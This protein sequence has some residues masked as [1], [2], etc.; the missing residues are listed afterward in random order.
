MVDTSQSMRDYVENFRANLPAGITY[1]PILSRYFCNDRRFLNE[2]EVERYLNYIKKFGFTAISAYAVAGLEPE[3]V[4]DFEN[5]V[6]RTNG[7]TSTFDDA[8]TFS[9]SG[10]ATMV[11]SDGVLKWAPHNLALNSASPATQSITVVSG[12][13]YT[14]E[15]TGVSIALSGAGTGTVTE[16]S[17]VEITASTTTLTLTVTGSTGTMWVYR[18]D[19]GGMVNNPDTGDSYVPTTSSAVYLPRRGHHVYNGSEWVNEGVLVESEARTN[20]VTYSEDFTDASWNANG[21]TVSQVSVTAPDGSSESTKVTEDGTADVHQLYGQNVSGDVSTVTVS[22]YFKAAEYSTF[23]LTIGS[24]VKQ[25]YANFDLSSGTVSAT[26]NS[27]DG[28]IEAVGNGWYRCSLVGLPTENGSWMIFLTDGNT[29]ASR[30]PSYTG[31][32]T[33]GIYIYGAQLEEGSTPSSYIPTS[34]STVTRAADSITVPSAKLPWPTPNVIGPELVTNGTFDTDSDWTLDAASSIAGGVLSTA[35]TSAGE[36]ASQAVSITSGKVYLI[37]YTVLS[38]DGEFLVP[39]L[40]GNSASSAPATTTTGTFSAVVTAVSDLDKFAFNIAGNG[41]TATIDNISVREID[42]LAVSIQMQ[43]RMT[44]AD[45]D[46]APGSAGGGGEVDFFIWRKGSSDFLDTV[47]ETT[48]TRTGEVLFRQRESTSGLDGADSSTDAY[49]PGL[50][51]PFNIASRHG[52][53][54]VNGAVD[55]TALTANTTPTAL[56]DLSSTDLELAQKYMGTI[57]L[58]RMWAD[59]LGDSGIEEAS[60]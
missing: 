5:E 4:F 14:V 27:G 42:P 9:R 34:G 11:D 19:L 6:Y 52:S 24:S 37:Q 22:G 23:Q 55:G 13:D 30:N 8:M 50:N 7:S 41:L 45:T 56:P 33:S 43:G 35:K 53:T 20:L 25:P 10:N 57:K 38:T 47:L 59:D 54:F 48:G 40:S 29:T 60:Q 39:R 16:G 3:L 49:S 12:A 46:T 15:C 2:W 17:P 1:D 58:F 26:G 44:Y 51:V 36:I 18:S 32:G 31:D 28:F 21:T